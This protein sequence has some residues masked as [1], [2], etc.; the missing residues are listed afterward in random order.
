M[1]ILRDFF[2]THEQYK[3]RVDWQA[4]TR[5]L[6]RWRQESFYGAAQRCDAARRCGEVQTAGTR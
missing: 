5:S 3:G 4:E 2:M 1:H 6:T